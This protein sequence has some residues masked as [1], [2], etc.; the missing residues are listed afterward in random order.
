[1]HEFLCTLNLLVLETISFN[2]LCEF[3]KISVMFKKYF[4]L[5]V[6]TKLFNYLMIENLTF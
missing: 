3:I 2:I 1:M 4:V 5:S 6:D